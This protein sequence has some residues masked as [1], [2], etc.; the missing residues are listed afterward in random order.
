MLMT[1]GFPVLA[2]LSLRL[3]RLNIILDFC[4]STVLALRKRAVLLAGG[5]PLS[6]MLVG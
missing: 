6:R 3:D 2:R 5:S 1:V 4:F